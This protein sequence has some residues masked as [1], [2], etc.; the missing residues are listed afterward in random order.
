[1]EYHYVPG[2]KQDEPEVIEHML[3][4]GI[5][6]EADAF[7]RKI[8][9]ISK[10][11]D[12][13]KANIKR[14]EIFAVRGIINGKLHVV[15]FPAKFNRDLIIDPPR[16]VD[17]VVLMHYAQRAM[18]RFRAVYWVSCKTD[19]GIS[20]IAVARDFG[21]FAKPVNG[22]GQNHKQKNL[23]L[24]ALGPGILIPEIKSRSLIQVDANAEAS[25]NL[26][27]TNKLRVN[28]ALVFDFL[29]GSGHCLWG[30]YNVAE[31]GTV[32]SDLHFRAFSY[33]ANRRISGVLKARKAEIGI[34]FIIKLV[35]F[36]ETS[37]HKADLI[38]NL[39]AL[40]RP[41]ECKMFDLFLET[42]CNGWIAKKI[43]VLPLEDDEV[44]EII[45]GKKR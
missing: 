28:E 10:T 23:D 18:N 17:P 25:M 26:Q 3:Q 13:K 9:D 24:S 7:V 11:K 32:F 40:L 15:F 4:T 12:S 34:R 36:A 43:H 38:S 39:F 6:T 16:E 44:D 31:D 21:D 29:V 5:F 41:D 20:P 45:E 22:N 30:P 2:F 42:I 1:M 37:M 27:G 35:L 19:L 14:I 8:K 33:S